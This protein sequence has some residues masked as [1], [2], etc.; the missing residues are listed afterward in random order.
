MS[1]K[2]L[3]ADHVI[4]YARDTAWGQSV[5][6]FTPGRQGVDN[7]IE[8][9]GVKTLS[10]SMKAVRAEG[11]I[12][13]IGS[14]SG[15]VSE[16]RNRPSMLDCW[17]NNCIARGVAV[18]SRAQMEEMVAAIEASDIHPVLD[19]KKFAI[20]DTEEA[21]EHCVS[22]TKFLSLLP[23][24]TVSPV[25]GKGVRQDCHYVGVNRAR[26]LEA[27]KVKPDLFDV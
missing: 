17:L 15:A 9:G 8:V 23:K 25:T 1:L 27:M 6:D 2:R 3:G 11:V 5:K 4:N 13:C 18:G 24:L 20:H 16:R 14:I 19:S 10:E 26:T 21:F 12:S 7:V 22:M